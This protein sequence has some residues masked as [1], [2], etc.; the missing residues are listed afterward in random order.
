MPD[1]VKRTQEEFLAELESRFGKDPMAWAFVC[2]ACGDVATGQDFKD[3]LAAKPRLNRDMSPM[4]ASHVIGTICIGRVL[5]A[6]EEFSQDDWTG[7]GCDWAS[8][9]LIRGPEFV[10]RP[11]GV[12]MAAF[13]IAPA[14]AR[15]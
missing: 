1:V 3:A 4:M 8:F 14:P 6:L 10:I 13:A 12:E 9:G 15:A 2:P 7:R 5:G 11:D